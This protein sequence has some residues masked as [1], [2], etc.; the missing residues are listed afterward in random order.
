MITKI[1]PKIP[2]PRIVDTPRGTV[3]DLGIHIHEK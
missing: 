3:K 2:R 1:E